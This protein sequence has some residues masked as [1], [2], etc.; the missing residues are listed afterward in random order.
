MKKCF[1]CILFA[2]L[3]LPYLTQAQEVSTAGGAA[4]FLTIVPD[5]RSA[6]MGGAGIALAK[7]GWGIFYNPSASLFL[8]DGFRVEGGYAPWMRH[9]TPDNRLISI[10]GSWRFGG[11]HG[12]AAGYRRFTAGEVRFS[13]ENGNPAGSGKPR[14]WALDLSYG[15]RLSD[16]L[17]LSLTARYIYSDMGDLPGMKCGKA[18]AFDLGVTY[19]NGISGFYGATW[20]AA[21]LLSNVGS[22]ISYGGDS[23]E[24]PGRLTVGGGLSLPFSDN[25]QL[26]SAV[27]LGYQFTPS[28]AT[29][30]ETA[31]GMEYLLYRYFVLRTGYH[32]VNRDNHNYFSIG[33]G[34]RL[35]FLHLDGSY[36]ITGDSPLKNS[37][38]LSFGFV[39]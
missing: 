11:Q 13:D 6:G 5:A 7:P 3:C 1:T 23:Y 37:W 27:D 8:A 32:A 35:P 14:E 18:V 34:F 29:C 12:I 25:H 33:G 4:S 15:R 38:H 30:W 9:V 19:R 22:R 24:L 28:T 39:L 16:H 10:G 31:A 26:R 36:W 17:A 2:I 21:I 20:S